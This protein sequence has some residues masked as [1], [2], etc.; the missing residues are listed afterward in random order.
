M[1][2]KQH[3]EYQETN[4]MPL[5]RKQGCK[6]EFSREQYERGNWQHKSGCPAP[7]IECLPNA[8]NLMAALRAPAVL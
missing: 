2:S 5:A 7:L 6:C 3:A 4:I 1:A 8:A